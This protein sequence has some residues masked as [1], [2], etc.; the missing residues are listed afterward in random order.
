MRDIKKSKFLLVLLLVFSLIAAACGSDDGDEGAEGNEGTTETT[1]S[2]EVPEGG[3]LVIGAEQ[4]P[5]CVDWIGSC[6]GASWG[7][8][9]M[10]VTTM[11][12]AFNVVKKGDVYDWEPS[13]VLAGEPEL[14]EGPPQKVTYKI[15]PKAV[16][17][18]GTQITSKDFKYTWDQIANGKD[19]YDAT[20]YKSVE[21]VDASDPQTAVVTF[22]EPYPDWKQLFGAGFGILPAHLLEGKDR[23]A[24]MANGY[25]WSGGPWMIEQWAKG[26]HVT[27]VPNEKYWGDKPKLDKVTFKFITDTSAE[28]QA[29]KG[30][31]VL[32]IYPQPQLDAVDQINAGLPDAEATYSAETGSIEALWFN[33]SKAPFDN[34]DFRKAIAY[35][36]DRDTLVERLFGA[37]G[38]EAPMQTLNP[39]IL[40]KYADTKAF[41]DY[42]KD[43]AK[44]EEHMKKAGY[45]KGSDG[46][47]AK[48][49]QKASFTIK[50]TTN[51]K[52]RELTEQIIQ[53]QLK[54]LGIEMTIQNQAAGDLFGDQL[55]KGDFQVGLY[56][57]VLTAITPG[58]C[59]LMCSENIPSEANEFS[60]QN[61]QRINVPELDKELKAM[62][63]ELDD[64]KRIEI[65]KKSDAIMADN[66]VALPIDPLPNILLYSK[67][68][69]GPVEINDVMGP[70]FNMHLWGLKQ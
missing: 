13:D 25:K 3:E 32:A 15:N 46:S 53:Q 34:V 67:K 44:F 27:L 14:E 63:T 61:W 10:N 41:S 51:N 60:G 70:F 30:G 58:Y 8:W 9:T 59:N 16:W 20:G 22:K 47:W 7:Y 40:S 54:D 50:S 1:A 29:F 57:Q 49:G 26:S 52:R 2:D 65:S 55:P 42:K 31:E 11:P 17:S 69:V 68:I 18:D 6:A 24:E 28:F 12:R 56:A 5:D 38:V 62:D 35:A 48:G 21:G 33:H 19:I 43:E 39:P 45:T 23:N 37:V 4:E 36:I 66:M 64:D